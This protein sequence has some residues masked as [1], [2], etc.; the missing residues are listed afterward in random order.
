MFILSFSLFYNPHTLTTGESKYFDN[1]KMLASAAG[2]KVTFIKTE[3][4]Y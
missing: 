4:K 2:S 3:K 1:T